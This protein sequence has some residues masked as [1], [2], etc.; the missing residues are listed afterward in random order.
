MKT[1]FILSL[2]FLCAFY[3]SAH[4]DP[5]ANAAPTA[6]SNATIGMSATILNAAE[7]TADGSITGVVP[8]QIEQSATE[9]LVM[10]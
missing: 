8:T 1:R 5:N 7:I 9:M 3:S 10:Y 4:A 2:L 6:Q